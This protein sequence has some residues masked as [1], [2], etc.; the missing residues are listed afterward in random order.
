[1]SVDQ[2][3]EKSTRS[4][5]EGMS[6]ASPREVSRM[7]ASCTCEIRLRA[8]SEEVV[9]LK[10]LM[11]WLSD[12]RQLPKCVDEAIWRGLQRREW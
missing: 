2:C 9:Y 11:E 6:E 4:L 12:N 8:A 3:D 1:M 5:S 7:K 10:S